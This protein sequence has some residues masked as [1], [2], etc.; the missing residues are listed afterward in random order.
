[1]ST[2][3][4]STEAL[5][6]I[7]ARI[8]AGTAYSL[9]VKAEAREL[10]ID[11]LE[12]VTELRV[13]VC[14]ESEQQLFERIDSEGTEHTIRIWIRKK[15][16]ALGADEVNPLRLLCRQILQQV[17]QYDT[18]DRRVCVW[19]SGFES[20]EIADRTMLYQQRIFVASVILRVRVVA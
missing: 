19:Q 6:A 3:A 13:D 8:N 1:M 15:V 4:P 18:Q 7:A 17:D 2:I 9:D 5:Q 20:Q 11:P 12:E 10:A 16:A 14:H